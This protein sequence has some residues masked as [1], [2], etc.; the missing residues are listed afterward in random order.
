LKKPF[1][2]D[3]ISWRAQTV[4][5][6]GTKALALAYIDARDV[7]E[8]LDEVCGPENWQC[9]YSHA[10]K[11]TVCE[12]GIMIEFGAVSTAMVGPDSLHK[13]QWVWKSDG[14][15]DSDVE[16]EKGALSD[17][18]KR[19]AVRW[20]IGR[21]LYDL[22]SPW[23]PCESREFNGKRQFVKFTD[24]PWAHIRGQKPAEK[25]K[26]T[27]AAKPAS[28]DSWIEEQRAKLRDIKAHEEYDLWR[29]A[30]KAA[31]AKLAS[32]YPDKYDVL[33]VF[34]DGL[35]ANWSEAF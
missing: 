13:H 11:K 34:I 22:D 8:R 33:E 14:A 32:E 6:D 10:D 4:S 26:K 28:V 25:P 23:V 31:L 27:E 5:K 1:P 17:A 16:A 15:G 18:F 35:R 7:M 3:R 30:N 29:T 24:N 9:R 12:I 20:G 19:A 21:Y 2:Q